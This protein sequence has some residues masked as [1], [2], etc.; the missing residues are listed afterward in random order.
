MIESG[1]TSDLATD[2]MVRIGEAIAL[3]QTG[4]RPGCPRPAGPVLARH[5]RRDG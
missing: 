1:L 4:D 2:L 5:R 3:S